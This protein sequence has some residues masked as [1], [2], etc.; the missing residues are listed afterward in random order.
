MYMLPCCHYLFEVNVD[1]DVYL[2]VSI[3]YIVNPFKV[4]EGCGFV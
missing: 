2:G 3:L 4:Y 1:V